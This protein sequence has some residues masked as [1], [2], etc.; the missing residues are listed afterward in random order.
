M[1]QPDPPYHQDSAYSMPPIPRDEGALP[2]IKIVVFQYVM[3]AAFIFLVSGYWTLQIQN[4]QIY[5]EKAVRNEI[6]ALPIP[7]PRGKILD[8]DGRV[9]VGNLASY[10]LLLSRDNL[11]E[12]HIIPIATGLNLDPKEFAERLRRYRSLPSYQPMFIKDELT[13]AEFTFVEANRDNDALPELELISSQRR[14]YPQDG[15]GAHLLGY[16]SEINDA[17]LNTPEWARHNPGDE[18]GKAGIERYYNDALTGVDGERQVRV[19]NR[20]NARAELGIKEAVPGKDLMLTVDL[21]LQIVAELSM[22]GRNGAVVAL[23]PRTGEVLALVSRPSYDPNHFVG[24]IDPSEWN[25]LLT[26]PDKPLF[27]RALQAQLAPGST[28]KPIMALA[29]L[30][31]GVIDENFTVTCTGGATW[32]GRPFKC[33]KRGGHGTVNLYKAIAQSCDV[34]FYA[35][36]NKLGIDN[37]AKYAEMAGFGHKT[38]IDLPQEKEGVV[39]STQWKMRLFREK[40]FAGETISVA[41]GQG[42]LTVTPLQ[43]AYA[44]GGIATGGVWMKPHLVKESAALAP[45]RKANLNIDHVNQVIQGMWGVVNDYGT[46]TAARLPGLD[47]CG[48]TGTAQLASNEL[49]KQ[50]KDLKDNAWFVGFAPKQAPEI[51]VAVLYE[52]GLHGNLAAPIARDVIKAYFDKKARRNPRAP[53]QPASVASMAPLPKVGAAQRP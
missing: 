40:W 32:Y 8:R 9:I 4:E 18:I 25:K 42:A 7:A 47:L 15:V 35:V 44:I 12:D 30:E 1:R 48:K 20:G 13:T 22:E 2:S 6:R 39:P 38:G 19:D 10:R 16:V 17:E 28:F 52:G 29:A 31:T 27:N 37:I 3:A 5:N 43:L 23:D 24:R 34:F 41:I 51:V 36:G 33:H 50:R 53:E 21:D 49:L 14:V 46:A 45:A 26:D 11:R